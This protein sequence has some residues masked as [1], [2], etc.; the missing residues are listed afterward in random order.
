M[1]E[2]VHGG[3]VC[4]TALSGGGGLVIVD[5]RSACQIACFCCHITQSACGAAMGL[6]RAATY[7]TYM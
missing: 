5:V 1:C 2:Y 4:A 3:L 6:V 7:R